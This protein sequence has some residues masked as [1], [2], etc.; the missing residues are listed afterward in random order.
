[1][2]RPAPA[3]RGLV[4]AAGGSRRLGR[5]KQTVRID[6]V[7]LLRRTVLI[8]AEIC[9]SPVTVV[10]GAN[11]EHAAACVA[12]LDIVLAHNPRWA[13]GLSGS[14][15]VGLESLAAGC[16]AARVVPCDLPRLSR[17]DL[18]SLLAA[19]TQAPDRPAAASHGGV[20]GAP[21]ILPE[22]MFPELLSGSGDTGAR[23]LLRRGDVPVTTVD[24]P[25][26]A[27]DLDRCED[28]P[29]PQADVQ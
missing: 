11:A 18:A 4:L 28:I 19:W 7:P 22:R 23:D 20:V 16:G 17:A 21:A 15:A 9:G 3:P 8:V 29:A 24:L 10:T 6:G 26:A 5:P 13:S 12:D 27:I 1:M 2:K 25:S 14:L